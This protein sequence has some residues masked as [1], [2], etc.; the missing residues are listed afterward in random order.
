MDI[1]WPDE[2]CS[3][4]AFWYSLKSRENPLGFWLK[5]DKKYNYEKVNVSNELNDT[6]IG[7]SGSDKV[8]GGFI[9]IWL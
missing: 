6:R 1:F 4:Q 9:I 2:L 8:K 7:N 5:F 3:G